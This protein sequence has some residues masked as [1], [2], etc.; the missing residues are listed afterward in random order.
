MVMNRATG[1]P[2]D[3]ITVLQALIVLFVA[4][5]RLVKYVLKKGGV[6]W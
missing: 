1:V 3:I 4:A 2:L 5:P 6:K